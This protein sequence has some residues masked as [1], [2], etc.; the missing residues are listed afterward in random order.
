MDIVLKFKKKI[1]VKY[2]IILNELKIIRSKKLYLSFGENCLSD[3]VLERYKLKSFTTPFSHGRCNIEYILNLEKDKYKGFT[4]LENLKYEDLNGKEVARLQN[5]RTIQNTYHELQMNGF[6]FTHHDIIK[7]DN[8]K[9]KFKKRVLKLLQYKGKK[10]YIILY[11]HRFCAETK[12]ELLIEHLNVLK[13]LYSNNK[14]NS[15]VVLFKQAIVPNELDRKI[16]YIQYKN[17]HIF[18]FYTLN[19]WEGDIPEI[20]WAKCD[21]DLI[22]K[23]IEKIK[24]L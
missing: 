2:N 20:L 5:Y 4:S 17:I 18:N 15:E 19:I 8:L 21:D 13:S 7:D 22:I 24:R 23:M 3:N 12:F 1:N 11:H 14:N 6:E 10:K 9:I 16:E